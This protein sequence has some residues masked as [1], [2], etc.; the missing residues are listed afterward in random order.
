MQ[1]LKEITS[2]APQ[3]IENQT[4][5]YLQLVYAL[6][7]RL[8]KTLPAS[9]KKIIKDYYRREMHSNTKWSYIRT[10]IEYTC[11][12]HVGIKLRS[13]YSNAL[14]YAYDHNINPSE[15]IKYMKDEGGIKACDGK[16]RAGLKNRKKQKGL[17][18]PSI[19]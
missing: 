8:G 5:K 16:F 4:Y 9:V 3:P 15:V 2:E 7:V 12:D 19:D 18:D 17:A 14:K 13:R 6:R 10:I 1:K 11:G